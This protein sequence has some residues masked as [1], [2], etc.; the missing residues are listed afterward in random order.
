MSVDEVVVTIDCRGQTL[1]GVL[2]MPPAVL[3][4]NE[5]AMVIV[6]GGPQYRAGSHRQF[7]QLARAVAAAGFAC[8]RFDVRGMGDSEGEPRSFEDLDDDIEAALD[9][10]FACLP[11]LQ[12]AVLWGLCDGASAALLYSDRRADLRV[13]ALGLANP[14]A[15]SEPTLART[16]L[17]H[18]YLQR[19]ADPAFWRKLLG[20]Q[21]KLN[22]LTE[23]GSA[24]R[25]ARSDAPAQASADPGFHGRMARALQQRLPTLL[26]LSGRDHTARE[27]EEWLRSEPAATQALQQAGQVHRL[28]EVDHTFSERTGSARVEQIT[29]DWLVM[30]ARP[31]I[32]KV[33]LP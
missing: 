32:P 24:M 27:F 19:L 12:R 6:V 9:T 30:L 10:L 29:I 22:A 26:L 18:Y 7:V 31:P 1:L 21:I 11:H 16:R 14:W 17:K 25:R 4:R 23:L 33:V 20:G 8:L 2:A 15:R 3:P 5:L 13:T 28:P